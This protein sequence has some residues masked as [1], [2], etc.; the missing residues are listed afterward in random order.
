MCYRIGMVT[1]VLSATSS[2]MIS[3]V[4]SEADL[5]GGMMMITDKREIR[6]KICNTYII[7]CTYGENKLDQEN[8]L[9]HQD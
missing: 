3:L 7:R 1:R 8:Q 2:V 5:F 6:K 9:I 4:S